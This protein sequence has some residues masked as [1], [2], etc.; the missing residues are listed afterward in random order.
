MHKHDHPVN[1]A[2]AR[3]LAVGAFPELAGRSLRRTGVGGTD[4]VLYRL[5]TDHVL[6]F[7]R[8]A[9][10]ADLL[11]LECRWLPVLAQHLPLAVPVSEALVAPGGDHPFPWALLR[12][13][14]GCD[15]CAHEGNADDAA[16]LAAS[17]CALQAVP[18]PANAPASR[19][20]EFLPSDDFVRQMIAIY[21]DVSLRARLSRFWDDCLA[22]ADPV[23]PKVWTHGDLHGLNV[24]VRRGRIRAVID[25]GRVGAGQGAADLICAW[26]M[27]S[28]P[29]RRHLRNL[30][31]ADDTSWA[32]GRAL[33]FAKA[34]MAIPYYQT[35][36]RR[37]ADTMARTLD[38]VL[39]DRD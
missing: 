17:I 24:L 5:G 20:V 7:P 30:L 9:I 34:V 4:N 28:A 29:A 12:W 27:L 16:S 36:N 14:P 22:G 3:V 31:G 1:P 35:T 23:G 38:R 25:W 37:F 21:P 11:R 13:L 10:A 6:R 8:I 15:A 39:A 19:A 33:A 18:V 26:T 2:L 32:R